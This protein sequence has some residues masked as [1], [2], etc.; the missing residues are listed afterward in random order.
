VPGASPKRSSSTDMRGLLSA[1]LQETSLAAGTY[2]VEVD[3]AGAPPW[4]LRL[5]GLRLLGLRLLGLRLRL[6]AWRSCSEAR[7]HTLCWGGW[8]PAVWGR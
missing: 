6:L 8:R 1:Q 7:Q 5:L 4:L 3:E 2:L